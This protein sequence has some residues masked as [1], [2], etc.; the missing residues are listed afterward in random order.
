M[1][2]DSKGKLVKSATLKEKNCDEITEEWLFDKNISNE[3]ENSLIFHISDL[4]YFDEDLHNKPF[5]YRFNKLQ[6]IIP[7]KLRFL[8]LIDTEKASNLKSFLKIINKLKENKEIL[9]KESDSKY[10]IILKGDNRSQELSKITIKE[11]IKESIKIKLK[12]CSYHG[13]NLVCPL[14]E[15]MEKEL[16]V[17]KIQECRLTNIFKCKYIRNSYYGY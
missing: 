5:S 10:P 2:Y 14:K 11:D 6:E 13:D 15:N 9:F 1:A 7:D 17:S 16:A 12:P 4:V 3:Q 8:K